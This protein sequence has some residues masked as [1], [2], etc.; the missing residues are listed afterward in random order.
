MRR[1]L[2]AAI[3]ALVVLAVALANADLLSGRSTP[4]FRDIATTQRPARALASALGPAS[5]NPH[6]SF[7]QPF[8][9]NPNLVLGYPF[10]VAPRWMG[11]HLLLHALLGGLGFLVFLRLLGRSPEA[12]VA[13]ALAFSF[14]GYALSSTAFLNA[15]TTLAFVPWLLASVAAARL[16]GRH[17]LR[18]SASTASNW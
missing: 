4:S 16:P 18:L 5:L 13:G 8:H 10:P 6:A 1:L 15:T 11:L 17:A 3:A 14:S 9:G 7:G 12:A 2:P